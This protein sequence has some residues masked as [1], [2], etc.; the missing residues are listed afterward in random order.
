MFP[1]LSLW[2]T[3]ATTTLLT[4]VAMDP[5]GA[6]RIVNGNDATGLVPYQVQ[7]SI[8]TTA[9][10]FMCGGSLLAADWVLTAAHCMTDLSASGGAVSVVATAG[11]NAA[12]GTGGTAPDGG[13]DLHLPRLPG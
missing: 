13:Q 8:T 10:Q 5:S 2:L 6:G 7:L 4:V 9:G 12:D 3:L 1:R 11:T